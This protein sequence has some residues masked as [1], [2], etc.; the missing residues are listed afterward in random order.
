MVTIIG[1][2]L[3]SSVKQIF[4]TANQSV[5]ASV[6]LLT[7]DKST[8]PLGPVGLIASLCDLIFCFVLKPLLSTAFRLFIGGGSRSARRKPRTFDRK[9]NNP[10]QLR[11]ESSA[12][13]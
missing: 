1:T 11:L 7:Y 9:T 3:S 4:E 13:A 6:Q 12:L 5:M 2:Y 10:S 8:L